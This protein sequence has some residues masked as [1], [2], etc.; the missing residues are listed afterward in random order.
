MN[1]SKRYALIGAGPAGLAGARALSQRGISFVGFEAH[2]DVGGLW[3][4]SSETSTMY[5]SAHL[6]SSKTTTAFAEYPMDEALPHYPHHSDMRQ[7]FSDYADRFGLRQHYRFSSKVTRCERI[8]SGWAV[9]WDKDG[10]QSSETFDGLIIANGTLAEPNQPEW[11]GEFSGEIMHSAQYHSP[12]IFDGKRVLVVGL[13]NSGADIAV[14]ACHR[15]AWVGLSVRRGYHFVPK[16]I[17]GRPADTIGGAIKLPFPIKQKVDS[18]LLKMLAGRGE[19]FG[20]PAADYK[21]YES[22]PVMNTLVLNHIGHGDIHVC[23]DIEK[24]DGQ[25][26]H[27]RGGN[28][29]DFDIIL[30]ATG[31]KLHYPF[32]EQA[33][34][35]WKHNAPSLYLNA[36]HPEANDLFILGMVEAAGLGWQGR[37]EQASLV[38]EYIRQHNEATPAATEFAKLKQEPFPS[39][40]GG[41]D[42][43][44]LARMAY[45]VNKD[46]YRATVQK[47]LNAFNDL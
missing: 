12:E 26:V 3:D 37:F 41:V 33:E 45:Y 6:I 42:Y 34:L 22:H 36:F 2:S 14:D 8:D 19:D 38:A 15:A 39:M 27:F 25:T 30:C 31:Y 23:G 43:L 35:N 21:L 20:L 24:F 32:I 17:M 11:P 46:V 44:D 1:A 4:I 47:H 10:Q 9:S 7:Y 18:F 29:Q 40:D 16:F 28:Q 5:Q 13:G